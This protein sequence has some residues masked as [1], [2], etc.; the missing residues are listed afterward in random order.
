MKYI[1]ILNSF[2]LKN[3]L[4]KIKRKIEGVLFLNQKLLN[5]NIVNTFYIIYWK[6][7]MILGGVYF[8]KIFFFNALKLFAWPL[9][10]PNQLWISVYGK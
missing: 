6:K 1:F 7:R 2:T 10:S 3:D 4:D 9:I 8:G 5:E